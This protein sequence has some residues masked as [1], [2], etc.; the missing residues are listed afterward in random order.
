MS[1]EDVQGYTGIAIAVFI[2]GILLYDVWA[3]LKAGAKGTVSYTIIMKWSRQYPAFTFMVG[4]AM[5]HLFWPMSTCFG[6]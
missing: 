5:G 4:F 1:L 6:N 3:Y 2:V